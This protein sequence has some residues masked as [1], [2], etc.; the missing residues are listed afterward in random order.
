MLGWQ[1]YMGSGGSGGKGRDCTGA[2]AAEVRRGPSAQFMARS[3]APGVYTSRQS[4]L[5]R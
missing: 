1:P 3:V 5:R 2:E 4:E